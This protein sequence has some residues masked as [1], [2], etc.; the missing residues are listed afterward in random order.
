M[1]T[2]SSSGQPR[3]RHPRGWRGRGPALLLLGAAVLVALVTV[4][5]CTPIS[6]VFRPG[7]GLPADELITSMVTPPVDASAILVRVALLVA[8]AVVAGLALVRGWLNVSPVTPGIRLLAWTG[9]LTV[10]VTCAAGVITGQTTRPIAAVQLALAMAVPL[11][12]GARR[13]LVG[14]VG[15]ALVGLL[16]VELGAA[17]TGLPLA[18]DVIYAVSGAV[19]FGASAFGVALLPGRVSPRDRLV[20]GA[21]DAPAPDDAE[22]RAAVLARLTWPGLIAATVASVAGI[23][24]ALVTGPRTLFDLLHTGYGLAALA[25]AALP[26]VV[27][28]TWYLLTGPAGRA[29]GPELSRLAAAGLAFAFLAGAM[30][31]TQPRPAAAPEPGQPLLRPVELGLRHLAV[32]VAPMRPGPNLVHIGDAGGGQALP[33]GHGHRPVAPVVPSSALSVSAGG[34][35]VPLTTRPGASGTWAVVDIPV[36][37]EQLTVTGD[38]VPGVVPIDVGT[39]PGDPVVTT[40]LTG[41]DGP[42]CVSAALAALLSAST[43]AQPALTSCPTE[44]LTVSDREAVRDTVTFLAGRGITACDLVADGSPRSRAAAELVRSEAATHNLPVST[45]LTGAPGHTVLVVSGW[46]AAKPALDKATA[47]SREAANGGIVV[48][49]WLLANTLLPAAESEVFALTFNP[50]ETAPRQYGVTAAAVFPGEGPSAAGYLAWARNHGIELDERAA[51]YGA[52][53][54]NVP[55]GVDM[56]MGPDP[57]AWYPDGTVVAINA[58]LGP[59]VRTP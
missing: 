49:P 40:A 46:A 21:V 39:E 28:L 27:A 41:V 51:F 30:L 38:G 7:A 1:T 37:T 45:G 52:A 20:H 32:L 55:M 12:L 44:M 5:V 17:R 13:W 23:T 48:A 15:I 50:Q 54:V 56:D 2:S 35:P 53:P 8:T 6:P 59:S 36:G 3:S 11:L 43:A 25:Q 9:A 19:L 16:G 26:V 10:T 31:A 33:G 34:A 4:L 18:L 57:G 47:Q 42:E 14:V 58:P 24:Q 22:R 29:R